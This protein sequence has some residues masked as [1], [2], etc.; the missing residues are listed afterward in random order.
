MV[1]IMP[2][3]IDLK[4]QQRTK[5]WTFEKTQ[6]ALELQSLL[7]RGDR[8]GYT[9]RLLELSK[10]TH[11]EHKFSR[12]K[13]IVY[14][15]FDRGE[16]IDLPIKFQV[17]NS[18][19]T[20]AF[21]A[22]MDRTHQ[23]FRDLVFNT[24]AKAHASVQNSCETY[25]RG[26][27]HYHLKVMHTYEKESEFNHNHYRTAN[28]GPITPIE[29]YQHLNAFYAQADGRKFIPTAEERD[30][31]I[32]KFSVF[33]ADFNSDINYV[34]LS[35][36]TNEGGE[37]R[38]ISQLE[39]I[40]RTGALNPDEADK[41]LDDFFAS[42][43]AKNIFK[44]A[45]PYGFP[46][47]QK[48][49]TQ[50]KNFI[51]DSYRKI[52]LAIGPKID[53]SL[54]PFQS[55]PHSAASSGY[56]S[57]KSSPRDEYVSGKDQMLDEI[58][59]AE[60]EAFAHDLTKHCQSIDKSLLEDLSL[61]DF[62]KGLILY[63]SLRTAQTEG[64]YIVEGEQRFHPDFATH[65]KIK[66]MI[67]QLPFLQQGST[68]DS[69]G[70]P[71]INKLIN[72]VT[73]ASPELEKWIEWVSING[74]RGLGSEIALVR[75]ADGQVDLKQAVQQGDRA[76]NSG[77]SEIDFE[78]VNLKKLFL[79]KEKADVKHEENDRLKQEL[80]AELKRLVLQPKVDPIDKTTFED[81]VRVINIALSVLAGKDTIQ[82]LST[83]LKTNKGW[84]QVS[85]PHM[86]SALKEIVTNIFELYSYQQP[87]ADA[88]TPS[89]K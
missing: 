40:A 26:T 60:Y 32:L 17:K 45:E 69:L 79:P 89:K 54:E 35:V 18:V 23:S 48:E 73:K 2:F 65:E 56:G 88:T 78:K 68:E 41:Q 34:A 49:I 86:K 24:A 62:R 53:P 64:G 21:I 12:T 8:K 9:E 1:A 51:K 47:H 46:S 33:W 71:L 10:T 13:G 61:E 80:A 11:G 84:Q 16:T 30:E 19:I 4:T 29:V 14:E 75:Q 85:M 70:S 25:Y 44:L 67:S 58:D 37:Q 38:I 20:W 83:E 52:Y 6:Y 7:D 36:M 77:V 50:I 31:I 81:K 22:P 27:N 87:S 55:D 82:S 39:D 15:I 42:A 76:A 3:N 5:I 43:H 28:D 59:K 63:H 57:K 74:S 66:E 72:W